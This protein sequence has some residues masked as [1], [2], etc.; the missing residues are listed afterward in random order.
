M[1]KQTMYSAILAF[2]ALTGVSSAAQAANAFATA[3]V[4]V[5]SGPSTSY[6]VVGVLG[7]GTRVQLSVCR[8]GWCSI[9]QGSLHGWANKSYLDKTQT[10]VVVVPVPVIIHAPHFHRPLRPHRPH[11][12]PRCKIAPG[13]SCR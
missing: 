9:E 5:R 12:K 7:A 10:S 2:A 11:L 3:E 6:D 1:K 8:D 4:N 13:F